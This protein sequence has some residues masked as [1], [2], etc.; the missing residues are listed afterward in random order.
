MN[1]RNFAA[2]YRAEQQ[3]MKGRGVALVPLAFLALTVLWSFWLVKDPDPG[4]LAAGYYNMLYQYP[5]M[6]AILMPV[7]IAVIASRIC[8]MEIKGGTMK[9]LFTV[10]KRSGFLDCKLLMG[11]KYLLLYAAGE[12]ALIPVL[13]R[14]AGF[15]QRFPKRLVALHFCVT[16]T[17]GAVLLLLQEMIS[18]YSENQILPLLVGLAGTF[19]GLFSMFFPDGVTRLVLWAY[20]A[21]FGTVKMNWDADTRATEFYEVPFRTGEFLVFLLIL[22]L[23][24]LVCRAV[25]NRK[26]V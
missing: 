22:A 19:L 17:V 25:L 24:W 23:A 10:Q 21:V 7:M 6:N 13:G 20:F 12:T 3:K 5:L 26:E 4:D 2:E 1:G 9:L 14:A 18:L 11:V 15:T 8:D 16:L